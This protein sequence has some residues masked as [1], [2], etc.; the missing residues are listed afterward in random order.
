MSYLIQPDSDVLLLKGIPLDI[1]QEHSIVFNTKTMQT[2]YFNDDRFVKFRF[3]DY[4]YQRYGLGVI[5]VEK[6][7]DDLYDVNYMMFRN[8][9]FGNKWFYAFVTKL[10]YINNVT[11]AVHYKIDPLQTWQF[12][13][14]VDQCFVVREMPTE[15]YAN[16]QLVD[17]PLETGEYVV[18][19]LVT[20]GFDHISD[21]D[22]TT[23]KICALVT[24][25]LVDETTTP[26]SYID[27]STT[28]LYETYKSP[29]WSTD[30]LTVVA[31]VR[32]GEVGS[33]RCGNL[34][35]GLLPVLFTNNE[36]GRKNLDFYIRA[37]QYLN[38]TNSVVAIF[39]VPNFVS[40]SYDVRPVTLDTLT[41]VYVNCVISNQSGG[42]YRM[43]RP[44]W[45]GSTDHPLPNAN[46]R[47]MKL[48][49]YPYCFP[50]LSDG[51]G[52]YQSFKP[53]LFYENDGYFHFDVLW[54]CTSALEIN[55]VPMYYKGMNVNYN[56]VFVF[57]RFPQISW[58]SDY[59]KEYWAK[60]KVDIT[61]SILGDLVSGGTSVAVGMS[62]PLP[63]QSQYNTF[64]SNSERLANRGV[65]V[66]GIERSLS[67]QLKGEAQTQALNSMGG[68]VGSALDI[69]NTIGNLG[70]AHQ[71]SDRNNGTQSTDVM[72]SMGLTKPYCGIM[73]VTKEMAQVIDDYFTRFGYATHR[74]KVPNWRTG[75][76]PFFNY[77][78]TK[79]TVITGNLPQEDLNEIV[80]I[81]EKGIT[82]WKNTGDYIGNYS[83]NN[84]ASNRGQ[85]R[86]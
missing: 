50:F 44:S 65:N 83:V 59:F 48:Y 80:S 84:M 2:N 13:F 45:I 62:T 3:T 81:F 60:N 79:D 70:I 78:Q 16:E 74:C 28:D 67:R 29:K 75:Q 46:I 8:T 42:E 15:D 40:A 61:T 69:A 54:C 53:Q 32:S 86:P 37:L 5:K 52:N 1:S 9:A 25:C 72:A 11:T 66:S 64:L 24:N 41:S 85:Y 20:G 10:E 51:Q 35:S 34:P 36:L 39:L 77:V 31:K 4:S 63:S 47:N 49:N 56:E 58:I 19:R 21:S 26:A 43:S 18:S 82:W 23:T 71:M 7:T 27:P 55:M 30:P 68:A 14:D 73:S 6:T 12:D 17:E 57:N 38:N 22:W 33:V 76:R